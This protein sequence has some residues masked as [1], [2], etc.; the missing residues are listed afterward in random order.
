VEDDKEAGEEKR[1]RQKHQKLKRNFAK[2]KQQCRCRDI[3]S[4]RK[5]ERQGSVENKA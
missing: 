2:S 4:A 5:S 3:V 1:F